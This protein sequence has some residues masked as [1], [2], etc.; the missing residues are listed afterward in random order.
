M[1]TGLTCLRCDYSLDGVRSARCPE[2]G[3]RIDRDEIVRARF[4]RLPRAM[5]MTQAGVLLAVL[6]SIMSVIVRAD[7]VSVQLS[8]GLGLTN[9]QVLGA[10]VSPAVSVV[11]LLLWITQRERLILAGTW[12]RVTALLAVGSWLII[13]LRFGAMP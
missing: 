1:H 5:L 9:D 4:D 6:H 13:S 8:A 10:F 11:M 12:A 7:D 2:C 3:W